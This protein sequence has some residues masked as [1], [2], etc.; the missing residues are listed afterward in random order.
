MSILI[1]APYLD[2]VKRVSVEYFEVGKEVSLE[3]DGIA[4]DVFRDV[5]QLFEQRHIFVH[6]LATKA[7]VT[8]R[9]I[10]IDYAAATILMMGT[11]ALVANLLAP[12]T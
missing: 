6:E 11:E 9:R 7:K 8:V 3:E 10:A 2:A 1:G 12:A 4:D 5:V